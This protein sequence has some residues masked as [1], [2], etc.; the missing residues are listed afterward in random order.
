MSIRNFT[1]H[2]VT[3][4]GREFQSEGVA[5]LEEERVSAGTVSF[6]EGEFP[7]PF[8]AIRQ[9][10]VTGLPAG[11]ESGQDTFIVSRPVAE[12]VHLPHI[13]AV[14]KPIRD[15][16]GRTVGAEGLCWFPPEI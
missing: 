1:P 14:D 4:A 3:V 10:V 13:V 11:W 15:A 6:L 12:A 8:A 7:C 5:R 16:D 2:P 9:G